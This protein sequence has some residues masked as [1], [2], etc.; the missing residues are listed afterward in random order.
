MK[1][2]MILP[3]DQSQSCTLAFKKAI[4]MI[5]NS[6]RPFQARVP[7]LLFLMDQ[8]YD[9]EIGVAL[10]EKNWTEFTKKLWAAG[11]KDKEETLYPQVL[12]AVEMT[13][14]T[15][16]PLTMVTPIEFYLLEAR[17]D[18]QVFVHLR[19]KK[20]QKELGEEMFNKGG[21]NGSVKNRTSGEGRGTTDQS[22]Q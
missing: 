5:K 3:Q 20:S 21:P 9:I 6:Q 8:D 4:E 18:V 22:I 13:K 2:E 7:I 15:E 14:Q 16:E 11:V 12:K 1:Q 10:K 19:K 17:F